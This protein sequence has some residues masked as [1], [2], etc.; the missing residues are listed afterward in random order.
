MKSEKFILYLLLTL[1]SVFTFVFSFFA[2]NPVLHHHFQQIAWLTGDLFRKYYF[3]F[4]GGPAEYM[5]LFVSQMFVNRLTGSL[6]IAFS[7]FLLSISIYKAIQLKYGAF[8]LQ[9]L[10]IPLIQIGLLAAMCD[11]KFN[12][13]VILNLL[14]VSGFLLLFVVFEKKT[15]VGIFLPLFAGIIIYYVNGGMYFLIFMASCLFLVFNFRNKRFVLIGILFLCFA[16]FIPWLANRFLFLTSL[17]NAYFR[18]TPDVAAMLRY[19]RQPVFFAILAFIPLYFLVARVLLLSPKK[20][21]GIKSTETN[22]IKGKN[23]QLSFLGFF[24]NRKIGT[25]VQ[26]FIFLLVSGFIL[27]YLCN[28]SEKKKLEIDF[29]ASSQNWEKVISLTGEIDSYDR[30]VNFQYNRALANTGQLLDKL[31]SYGQKLGSLGLFI[32]KPFTSEVALPNSDIYFDLGN[33]DESQRFAFESETL[34]K[35]SPRVLKRLIINC[36][37]M[38]NSGAAN[39]YMNILAANPLEKKWV[40]KFREYIKNPEMVNS[41]PLIVQKRKDMNKTEGMLGTPPLKLLSQLEK[42]PANKMAFEYLIAI[43]LM[44]HDA[45]ALTEDLKYIE[46]FKYEKLPTALEEAIILYQTQ[47]KNNELFNRIR[48]SVPT[49]ERFREFAKLTSA[50]KGNREK[51][52]QATIAFKNTYWY[53][54]L[55]LSPRVTNLKLETKPVE[56][57]Y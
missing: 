52:K 31:F 45:A 20:K 35:N 29:S 5:A 9:I 2:I 51:A 43:D 33:I 50:A 1:T 6:I 18:S 21:S 55:F 25:V 36:I 37:I 34:M 10:L 13:S 49:T 38:N 16:L 24:D 26:V 56:A 57:N 44:E 39:T 22:S 41:D 11:Y 14:F 53:Y 40:K 4:A 12:Y 19:E 30:M 42:N 15:R 32:D 27:Y 47:L 3:G 7:G 23:K 28:P 46:N 48:I 54:V 17:N 8:K